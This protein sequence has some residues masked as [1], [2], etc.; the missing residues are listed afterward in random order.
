M[1]EINIENK[2]HASMKLPNRFRLTLQLRHRTH[3]VLKKLIAKLQFVSSRNFVK[4]KRSYITRSLYTY[5]IH[6]YP[7]DTMRRGSLDTAS[8][9]V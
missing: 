2:V 9:V 4:I 8:G 7:G 6:S 3:K 1:Y 5:A